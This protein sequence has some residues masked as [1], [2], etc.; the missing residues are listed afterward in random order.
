VVVTR[1]SL[2][3]DCWLLTHESLLVVVDCA[4]QLRE[5][6]VSRHHATLEVQP[7]SGLPDSRLI[8]IDGG[9]RFGC[10]LDHQQ[11]INDPNQPIE[12]VNGAILSFGTSPTMVFRVSISPPMRVCTSGLLPSK[13]EELRATIANS[14]VVGMRTSLSLSLLIRTVKYDH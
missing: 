10:K 9:S 7:I 6:S 13:K 5:R 3:C 12:I 1:Y 4:I 14:Q 2:I 8:L 11:L